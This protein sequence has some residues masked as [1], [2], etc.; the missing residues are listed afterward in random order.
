MGVMRDT[1]RVRFIKTAMVHGRDVSW[2]E[3]NWN[4]DESYWYCIDGKSSEGFFRINP[5]FTRMMDDSHM[6]FHSLK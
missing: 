6:T 5:E 3:Y 2:A 1:V 4:S